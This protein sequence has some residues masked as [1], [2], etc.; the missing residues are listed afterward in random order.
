MKKVI[1]LMVIMAMFSTTVFA[2]P[3]SV[4]G[5]SDALSGEISLS[6][7]SDADLFADVQAAALTPEEV[8]AVEG[9]GWFNALIS[10]IC[11]GIVG[12]IA[13]AIGGGSFSLG[14]LSIPG[15]IA[16][17]IGGAA[18]SAMAAYSSDAIVVN[19]SIHF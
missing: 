17:A 5:S 16:G 13:G 18:S 4:A 11:G 14:I 8:Q 19:S 1:A 9:E 6:S 10:G 12:G 3:L 15:Y 7:Q 2:T